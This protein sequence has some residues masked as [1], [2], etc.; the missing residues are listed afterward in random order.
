[1]S[2]TRLVWRSGQ[3]PGAELPSPAPAGRAP[4]CVCVCVRVLLAI[5]LTE[6]VKTRYKCPM[7]SAMMQRSFGFKFF[8]AAFDMSFCLVGLCEVLERR[9]DAMVLIRGTCY[10]PNI[11]CIR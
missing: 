7:L 2:A 1:M 8:A 5:G 9:V 4:L 6:L 11:A 10:I 3:G